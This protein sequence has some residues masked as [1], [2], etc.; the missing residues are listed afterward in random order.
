MT[1]PAKSRPATPIFGAVSSVGAADT[2]TNTGRSYYLGSLDGLRVVAFLTVF[3]QHLPALATVGVLATRGWVGVELFF[4]ISTYLLF[5]LL[6]AEMQKDSR[7]DIRNFYV[8][9]VLR[10]YPLLIVFYSLMFL[11]GRGFLDGE[12][13]ARL[14]TTL[15]SVDNLAIWA[16]GWNFSIPAV[17]PL[18]S[19]SFEFQIY[20]LLP[21]AFLAWQKWGTRRFM[22]FL[23]AVELVALAARLLAVHSGLGMP[24]IYV[25]PYLRPE[26]ILLGLALAVCRPTWRPS[27]SVLVA[28]LAGLVFVAM[29][30]LEQRWTY[31]PVGLMV[32]AVTDASLRFR[33]VQ[34]FLS[35][36]PMR[37]LG[38]ISYGL[39]VF[40]VLAI[41]CTITGLRL[42]GFS[43]TGVGQG[44]AIA[45]LSLVVT[46][47]AAAIS[48]QFLERPFL[49]LKLRFSSVD[50]RAT[51]PEPGR[52]A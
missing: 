6:A 33:P 35:L 51:A 9:R 10:I 29:P 7:I 19:L 17:G 43:I 22:W 5:T 38:K 1:V 13:W 48:Y 26:S 16:W 12:A 18:W 52:S 21:F 8:R 32:A 23:I 31:L 20:L 25:T 4:V 45:V 11:G 15:A 27:L 40:H 24:G 2:A 46:T 41:W 14:A 44:V 34:A 50:G 3:F 37:Y 36:G 49:R 39:Y 30:P 42:L 28:V 47:C